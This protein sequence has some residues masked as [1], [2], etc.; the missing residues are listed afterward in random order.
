MI[1]HEKFT[2]PAGIFSMDL[3]IHS[4]GPLEEQ[5]T[6]HMTFTP[7]TKWQQQHQKL[8]NNNGSNNSTLS[9][10]PSTKL[11]RVKGTEFMNILGA[12]RF[13]RFLLKA[14]CFHHL[15]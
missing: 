7:T 9:K 14:I 13:F 8:Q 12:V 15:A 1:S 5:L 2:M 4:K 11:K 10:E 3:Y 6:V